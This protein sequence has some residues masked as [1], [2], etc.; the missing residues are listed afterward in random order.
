MLALGVSQIRKIV[1]Q[2]R[3]D[4][5]TLMWSATWPKDVQTLASEFLEKYIQVCVGSTELRANPHISQNF[6]FVEGYEK[7][8]LL[9]RC[10]ASVAHWCR[11]CAH[12][13]STCHPTAKAAGEAHGWLP[14]PGVLRD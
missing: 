13:A 4:R 6:E 10:I 14:H 1:S 9:V 5:Q 7:Q 2:I 8:R 12:D 3:P 11:R